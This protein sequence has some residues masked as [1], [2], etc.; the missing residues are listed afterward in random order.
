MALQRWFGAM[1]R[2]PLTPA[3]QSLIYRD[4]FDYPL[5]SLD[6][7]KR[8]VEQKPPIDLFK[9]TMSAFRDSDPKHTDPREPIVKVEVDMRNWHLTK[10][11]KRRLAFLLGPRYVPHSN[12]FKVVSRQ[13][14]SKELNLQRCQDIISELYLES[15][16][17]P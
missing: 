6:E 13:F 10:L 17:A 2:K 5:R 16:R 9:V 12:F 11:Q 3:W 15:K 8:E 7:V 14:N 4:P 1:A